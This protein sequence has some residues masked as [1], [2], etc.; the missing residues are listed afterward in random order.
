MRADEV[1]PGDWIDGW[2]VKVVQHTGDLYPDPDDSDMFIV[3]DR[4]VLLGLERK[5]K[6]MWTDDHATP[7]AME[8]RRDWF[9]AEAEIAAKRPVACIV[10]DRTDAHSHTSDKT[11]GQL[12]YEKCRNDDADEWTA[13]W[14]DHQDAWERA[15]EAAVQPGN[16]LAACSEKEL[17]DLASGLMRI[18]WVEPENRGWQLALL[19]S[20]LVQKGRQG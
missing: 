4:R 8:E 2:K 13:L 19:W 1:R 18:A 10:C 15:A 5:Q 11:P 6:N 3:K 14:K 9:A 12:L 7:P 17:R 20:A 16:G